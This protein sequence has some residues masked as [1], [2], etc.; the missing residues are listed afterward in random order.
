LCWR[1]AEREA[2][3]AIDGRPEIDGTEMAISQRHLVIGVTEDFL[4]VLQARASQDHVTRGRMPKIVEP[5][6]FDASA[7]QSGRKGCAVRLQFP[8]KKAT[9]LEV[10][11]AG[12]LWARRSVDRHVKERPQ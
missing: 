1:C 9:R 7:I 5:E 10:D 12:E 3:K 8:C 6:R 2:V 4:H 11:Q